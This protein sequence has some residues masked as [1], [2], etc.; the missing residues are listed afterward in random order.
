MGEETNY[1]ID[2]EYEDDV[3]GFDCGFEVFNAYLKYNFLDD[4]AV[5]HYAI[6]AE[7][8]ELIAYFSLLA[9]C[10]FL[11]DF[12][13]SN[14]IPAIELKMFAIDKKFRRLPSQIAELVVELEK[15]NFAGDINSAIRYPISGDYKYDKTQRTYNSSK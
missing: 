7:N 5:I 12:T 2:V 13:D 11:S 4:K 6:D 9:S 8:G 14:V 15:G 3:G 10:I 1:Y